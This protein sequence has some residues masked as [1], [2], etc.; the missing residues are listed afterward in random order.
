SVDLGDAAALGV[1]A[2]DPL[3]ATA[4]DTNGNSSEFSPAILAT[5]NYEVINFDGLPAQTGQTAIDTLN[6]TYADLGVTF[7]FFIPRYRFPS[8]TYPVIGSDNVTVATC[9]A[10]TPRGADALISFDYAVDSVSVN[11]VNT[12]GYIRHLIAYNQ[13]GTADF[14]ET[15]EGSIVDVVHG[16]ANPGI[17]TISGSCIRSVQIENEAFAFVMDD[18]T[19]TPM[20][21]PDV[22]GDGL[23]NQCDPENVITVNSLDDGVDVNVGDG[24]CETAVSG[25]CTLR[26][27]I[28]EANVMP[29][30]ERIQFVPTLNGVITLS[31]GQIDILD[32]LTLAGPGANAVT[33]SGDNASRIF[34]IAAAGQPVILSD[35]TFADGNGLPIGFGGAITSYSALTIQ[36]AAFVNNTATDGSGGAIN[37]SGLLTLDNVTFDGNVAS[38]GNGGAVNLDIGTLTATGSA[39][40]NNSV[41]GFGGALSI[42]NE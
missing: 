13:V 19:F 36:D 41:S 42:N 3:V 2:G 34:N 26:A 25:Q 18:I 15:Q 7:D 30:A 24:V 23:V 5:S 40:T 27:A 31:G 14:I 33:V 4:T 6:S 11:Y 1:A 10:D 28:Q 12:G 16:D 17:L 20:S 32:A 21:G 37:F 29:G 22:D 38:G 39:M 35:L 9:C 8:W